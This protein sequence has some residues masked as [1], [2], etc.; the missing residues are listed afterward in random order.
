LTQI[1]A[2]A[3][4]GAPHL[5]GM[6]MTTVLLA[7]P[8]DDFCLF[9]QLAMSGAQCRTIITGSLAEAS[10]ALDNDAVDAVITRARL[11]DGS[12]RTLARQAFQSGMLAYVLRGIGRSIEITDH[13]GVVF[14][15]DRFAVCDF[16]KKAIRRSPPPRP[17]DQYRRKSVMIRLPRRQTVS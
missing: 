13:R 14:R 6:T 15:G 11:P 12:G 3:R 5:A 9:L 7:E 4:Q 1:D 17:R 10:H 16:L 2:G 8:D